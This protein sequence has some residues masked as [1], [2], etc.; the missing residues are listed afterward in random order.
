[1]TLICPLL[2]VQTPDKPVL[3]VEENCAWY[4]AHAKQCA[5]AMMGQSAFMQAHA[6]RKQQAPKP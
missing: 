3:C 4:F 5:L 2:S 1:M 6:L